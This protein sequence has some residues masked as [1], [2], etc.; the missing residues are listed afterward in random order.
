LERRFRFGVQASASSLQEWH[1]L[2]RKLEDL[3]FSTLV[4]S[5]HFGAQLAPLLALVSAAAV[6]STLRLGAVVLDNDFRHPAMVAK[7][8]ATTDVLTGGRFEFGLGAGWVAA[9]YEKTGLSFDPPALRLS[10]LAETIRICKSFFAEEAVT[11]GGEHYRIDGLDG[12]PKTVQQ[13]HPPI[14]IGGRQQRMLALAGRE[15]D[16]VGISMLDRTLPATQRRPFSEKVDWVRAAAGSRYADIELQAMVAE[17]EIGTSASESIERVAARLGV[18]PADV[19]ESPAVLAGDVSA[20]ID[21]LQAWRDR[22]D[23]SY[24]VLRPRAI[25][26]MAPVVAKLAGA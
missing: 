15:A 18:P 20:V 11:F 22:S 5:D 21:Q 12:F 23:L 7:E 17:V 2:A 3:G 10:R 16:I 4:V 13:P 6:T 8:A 14:M 24:F 25:D 9:D 26:A 19:L 1:A